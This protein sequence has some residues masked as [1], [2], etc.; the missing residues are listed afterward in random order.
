M[1]KGYDL[2]HY[3]LIYYKPEYYISMSTG[4]EIDRNNRDIEKENVLEIF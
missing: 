3:Q 4:Y 1:K 2:E